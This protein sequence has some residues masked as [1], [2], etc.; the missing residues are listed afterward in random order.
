M[1]IIR[2]KNQIFALFI[3]GYC[4][5]V[6]WSNDPIIRGVLL[7]VLLGTYGYQISSRSSRF[8]S[9]R[10]IFLGWIGLSYLYYAVITVLPFIGYIISP[11]L[12]TG[13][14]VAI[15]VYYLSRRPI[16]VST[17]IE[18]LIAATV[19]SGLWISVNLIS[20]PRQIDVLGYGY[21]NYGHLSQARMIH[22]ENHLTMFSGSNKFPSFISTLAQASSAS[23]A[24]LFGLISSSGGIDTQISV[25]LFITVFLPILFVALTATAV[26]DITGSTSK[27]AIVIGILSSYVLFGYI[28]HV[29]VSGYFASTLATV[30]MCCLLL[31]QLVVSKLNINFAIINLAFLFAIYPLFGAISVCILLPFYYQR[32]RCELEDYS[33]GIK[34]RNELIQLISAIGF[35]I[36]CTWTTYRAINR[37]YGTSHFLVD[38]GIE[39]LPVIFFALSLFSIFIVLLY[40]RKQLPTSGLLLISGVF[41]SLIV[42]SVAGYSEVRVGRLQ[43]YPTKIIIAVWLCLLATSLIAIFRH[44]FAKRFTALFLLIILVLPVGISKYLNEKSVFS[45]AFM[46]STPDAISALASDKDEVVSGDRVV[47]SAR[48]ASDKGRVPLFLSQRFDSELNTRWINTINDSWNDRTWSNWMGLRDL[49][50]K[51][52]FVAA[53]RFIHEN[54]MLII[55]GEDDSHSAELASFLPETKEAGAFCVLKSDNSFDCK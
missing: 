47:L 20:L 41:G 45:G 7:F 53:D 48:L 13:A 14:V 19:L 35:L 40:V 46:G 29:W 42:V 49:I 25:M 1:V 31:D 9:L 27:S 4:A 38:G 34:G 51:K 28:S 54:K 43:Y 32:A 15:H 26:K 44:N 55:M 36:V 17:K 37:A 2:S 33:S 39:P 18:S 10:T 3:I 11:V 8:S 50:A 52:D 16:V 30:F 12:A 21:D 22:L 5:V 24:F 23:L 6:Y